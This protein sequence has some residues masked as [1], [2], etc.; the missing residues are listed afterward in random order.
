MTFSQIAFVVG[1]AVLVAVGT[2]LV[3]QQALK[4]AWLD[5]PNAR[6]SHTVPTPRG[7]GIAIAVSLLIAL[8]LA[9][10]FGW[11]SRTLGLGLILGGALVATIGWMDDRRSVGAAVR[12]IV[13]LTA[14]ALGVWLLG[15]VPTVRFGATVFQLGPAGSVL[16]VLFVAWCVNLY[17]F[18]DGIDGIAGTEAVFVGILAG[19]YSLSAPNA[20]TASSTAHEISFV[21]FAVAAAGLGF[22]LWNWAPARIFMG[23][24]GSGM[25]GYVFGTLALASERSGA[26]PISLWFLLLGV[27]I[28][29]ATVTLV[30]RVLNGEAWYVAHRNH[31]YQRLVIS[32]WSHGRVVLGM[33]AVNMLL[34]LLVQL[35]LRRPSLFLP[36]LISGLFLL[37]VI[38]MLIDRRRPMYAEAN[39]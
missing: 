34:A 1:I 17:N 37:S 12:I 19:T 33:I 4:H 10:A 38:Y 31:A 24:A 14:A 28:F 8:A 11:V 27:F 25:L 20:H 9:T 7:G 39:Q 26:L 23:D 29:D 22:L 36:C 16:A 13:H 21:A 18:M 2:G 32:G 30:R 35:A 3:R 6:S 15:G 5:I